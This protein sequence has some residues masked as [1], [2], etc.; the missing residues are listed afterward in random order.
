[1]ILFWPYMAVVDAFQH[2]AY[3]HHAAATD[4][5]NC[6]AK[7]AELWRRFIKGPDWTGFED[8]A[9]TGWQRKHHI[10]TVPLYYVEYGLAQLGAVQVWR[11]SLRDEAAAVASYRNALAL[12]GTRSVPA[13]FEAAGARFQPDAATLRECVDLIEQTIADLQQA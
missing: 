12:G 1:M 11:N 6:D 5:A 3:N 10:F 4:P 2:W 9:A 8:A 13:L 7:W